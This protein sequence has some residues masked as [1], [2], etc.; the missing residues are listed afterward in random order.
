[1]KLFGFW[2]ELPQVLCRLIPK[3]SVQLIT[4]TEKVYEMCKKISITEVSIKQ[5]I[6]SIDFSI[7]SLEIKDHVYDRISSIES[8]KYSICCFSIKLSVNIINSLMKDL[9]NW[10]NNLENL[11]KLKILLKLTRSIS[12]KCDEEKN[13]NTK[14]NEL[15]ASNTKAV[16]LELIRVFNYK[17]QSKLLAKS[18]DFIAESNRS[19]EP[20]I[21]DNEKL[22]YS[23][24]L[25][26]KREDGKFSVKPSD[27][28]ADG[29]RT[30]HN[31]PKPCLDSSSTIVSHSELSLAE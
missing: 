6:E 31:T 25:G 4:Q 16:F 3:L 14:Q 17:V 9:E 21:T 15:Q 20:I 10:E 1:M 23:N 24:L 13:Y 29:H 12:V 11:S 30:C 28:P 5:I 26:K 27:E 22:D 2:T 7:G 8:E 19:L 18:Q